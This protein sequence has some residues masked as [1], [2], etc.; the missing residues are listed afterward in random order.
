VVVEAEE[1]EVA[2][3]K[4]LPRRPL[5]L[6]RKK[7]RRLPQLLICSAV[8]TSTI[9]CN[10]LLQFTLHRQLITFIIFIPYSF[11]R[12]RRRRLL[13]NMSQK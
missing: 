6:L 9:I 1:E 13:N 8:S 11:F 4:L 5:L 7:L 10:K 3:E 12:W 2:V